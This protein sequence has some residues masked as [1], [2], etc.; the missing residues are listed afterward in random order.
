M[1]FDCTCFLRERLRSRVV[2]NCAVAPRVACGGGEFVL[3]VCGSCR[4]LRFR[5]L[6]GAYG[7]VSFRAF[8]GYVVLF[9][10]V[11]TFFDAE[12]VVE[13]WGGPFDMFRSSS[14]V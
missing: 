14:G 6:I 8:F 9:G 7:F 11:V 2:P 10:A 4:L 12:D 3:V 5:L 13:F 1:L